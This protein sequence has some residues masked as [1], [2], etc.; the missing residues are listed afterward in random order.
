METVIVADMKDAHG[1]TIQVSPWHLFEVVSTHLG[2]VRQ[3]RVP[4]LL[5][6]PQDQVCD[7]D[8]RGKEPPGIIGNAGFRGR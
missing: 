2:I 3:T 5:L 6:R 1:P 4:G 7:L 8:E